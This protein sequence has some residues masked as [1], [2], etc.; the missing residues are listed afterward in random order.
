M[1]KKENK[2]K[3]IQFPVDIHVLEWYYSKC[4]W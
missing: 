1:K 4:R 3:K 2:C